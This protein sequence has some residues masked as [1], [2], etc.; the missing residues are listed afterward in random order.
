[1]SWDVC[2]HCEHQLPQNLSPAPTGPRD[3]RLTCGHLADIA[4]WPP[5]RRES[6][7]QRSRYKTSSSARCPVASFPLGGP[8]SPVARFHSPTSPTKLPTQLAKCRPPSPVGL[9][10]KGPPILL[11][12]PPKGLLCFAVPSKRALQ[13]NEPPSH[14]SPHCLRPS[15]APQHS[16]ENPCMPATV[17]AHK[18]SPRAP[19]AA[20]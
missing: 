6:L 17:Q 15:M 20:L 8:A 16:Q 5:H 10:P 9:H 1:M 4:N 3:V 2:V 13:M 7:T 19:A 14:H 11:R 12:L 18:R